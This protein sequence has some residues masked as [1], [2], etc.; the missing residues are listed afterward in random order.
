MR[1]GKRDARRREYRERERE[2]GRLREGELY[3]EIDKE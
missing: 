1:K 2:R 3:R